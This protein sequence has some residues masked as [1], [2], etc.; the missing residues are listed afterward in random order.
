MSS[1]IVSVFRP[2]FISPLDD[3]A[4]DMYQDPEVGQIIRKLEQKKQEA[5]LRMCEEKTFDMPWGCQECFALHYYVLAS[6]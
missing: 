4:F 5:V 2:D 1:K 6:R 3:L